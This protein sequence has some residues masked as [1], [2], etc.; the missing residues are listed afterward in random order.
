M[1]LEERDQIFERF[2]RSRDVL[3]ATG[4]LLDQ[5]EED[6]SSIPTAIRR[7]RLALA[8]SQY[9]NAGKQYKEAQEALLR[10]IL[11]D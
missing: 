4:D 2:E 5:V 6:Y 9:N 11:T 3:I 1:N 8:V 10:F 7:S